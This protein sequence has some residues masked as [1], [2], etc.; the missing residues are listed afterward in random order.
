MQS[1][2]I[3]DAADAEVDKVVK[4][5]TEGLF[6]GATAAPTSNIKVPQPVAVPAAAVPAMPDAPGEEMN[7]T[8]MQA[9]RARLQAL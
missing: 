8:D 7:E 2:G 9:M 4:E 6:E 1:E 3:D 5:L